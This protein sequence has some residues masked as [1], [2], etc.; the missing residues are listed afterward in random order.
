MIYFPKKYRARY[1]KQSYNS[2]HE[3]THTNNLLINQRRWHEINELDEKREIH[4]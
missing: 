1:T 2:L 3:N 4:V